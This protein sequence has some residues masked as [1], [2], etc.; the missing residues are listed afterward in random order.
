[1]TGRAY[2]TRPVGAPHFLMM[3]SKSFCASPAS[4][5]PCQHS[6]SPTVRLGNVDLAAFLSTSGVIVIV[7]PCL[8]SIGSSYSFAV[9]AGASFVGAGGAGATGG[10]GGGGSAGV[11]G[12]AAGFPP[13]A[14]R[15]RER[16]IGRIPLMLVDSGTR[17]PEFGTPC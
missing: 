5:V 2:S 4:A 11:V 1:M 3:M 14:R 13:H 15:R 8:T 9:G 12:G 7:W 6:L 17:C 16:G 10:G